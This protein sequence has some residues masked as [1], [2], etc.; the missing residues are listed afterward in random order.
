MMSRRYLCNSSI[1]IFAALSVALCLGLAESTVLY[2]NPATAGFISSA[3]FPQPYANN[4]RVTWSLIASVGYSIIANITA[5]DLLPKDTSSQNCTDYVSFEFSTII[6]GMATRYCGQTFPNIV[7]NQSR[8]LHVTFYSSPTS[9]NMSYNG[10]QLGYSLYLDNN[11]VQLN[12]SQVSQHG[13]TSTNDVK[14]KVIEISKR[15]TNS[16]AC[17]Y[18][19]VPVLNGTIFTWIKDGQILGYAMSESD[20]PYLQS[21][22][23][24]I[25]INSDKT[26][27]TLTLF[28]DA[29]FDSYGQYECKL[30]TLG[31]SITLTGS[32]KR[33]AVYSISIIGPGAVIEG[34][35]L[36]LD[37]FAAYTYGKANKTES[38]SWSHDGQELLPEQRN[39]TVS[40]SNGIRSRLVITNFSPISNQ[41]Y[42]TVFRCSYNGDDGIHDKAHTV[43]VFSSDNHPSTCHSELFDGYT[44]P[45]TVAGFIAYLP[46]PQSATGKVSRACRYR[47]MENR[48]IWE[49]VS[50]VQCVSKNFNDLSKEASN[51]NATNNNATSVLITLQ[52][53]T[54]VAN[55]ESLLG[56]DILAANKVMEKVASIS[57]EL[58]IQTVDLYEFIKTG[59]NLMEIKNRNQWLAIQQTESG[60]TKLNQILDNYCSRVGLDNDSVIVTTGNIVVEINQIFQDTQQAYQFPSTINSIYP[61]GTALPINKTADWLQDNLIIL[62]PS[63]FL[64]YKSSTKVKAVSI[65]YKTLNDIIP[66]DVSQSISYLNPQSSFGSWIPQT[67]IISTSLYPPL[68]QNLNEPLKYILRKTAADNLKYDRRMYSASNNFTCAFWDFSIETHLGGA[69]SSQGCYSTYSNETFVVCECDHLTNFAVLM[70]LSENK[71]SASVSRSLEIITYIGCGLSVIGLALNIA[72]YAI[73]WKYLKNSTNKIHLNLFSWLLVSNLIMILIDLAKSV[74]V[75]CTTLAS[76]L[77]FSLLTSFMWMLME[78][79][80]IYLFLVKVFD[81]RENF[82]YYYSASLGIPALIS[83]TT[84]AIVCGIKGI[85]FYLSS[86]GC[87]ISG[88]NWIILAFVVPLALV[89]TINLIFCVVAIHTML[90]TKRVSQQASDLLK[91]K[92]TL[93]GLSV[94]A[95]ILGLTWS[96]GC[97]LM[98]TDSLFVQY[99]FAILNSS[100]G[101][102]IFG[103]YCLYNRKVR[104]AYRKYKNRLKRPKI[105]RET[106]S[107]NVETAKVTINISTS[108]ARP[109]MYSDSAVIEAPA[110]IEDKHDQSS[111]LPMKT[112]SIPD[113]PLNKGQ[114]IYD[115]INED[116]TVDGQSNPRVIDDKE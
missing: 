69:W 43:V 80:H 1:I 44:W 54:D 97:I 107:H 65:I 102:Y 112:L 108:D 83:G 101:L 12:L 9:P 70:R 10:F 84:A 67:K 68:K 72:A 62:P 15:S 113:C 6:S 50:T 53:I 90:N 45:E 2:R 79:I 28:H 110:T 11:S 26:S 48:A 40:Q 74:T 92:V 111:S 7:Y 98:W 3:N 8:Y 47:E 60:T 77:H 49:A 57:N 94:L 116:L 71:L 82:L 81:V 42:Q 41:P 31:Q 5:F 105:S 93:R 27:T 20:P 88:R 39:I 100:Q 13:S 85:K 38:F 56:G 21:G 87:W 35:S 99:G 104:E 63:A 91:A 17:G 59:S 23:F 103:M 61:N 96:F 58:S 78:G 76:L 34:S 36:Q 73:L 55:N 46:C 86:Q 95:P 106:V 30:S 109:F 25:A 22:S 16:L 115:N 114:L 19:G 33:K 37:C 66:N 4:Q 29:A 51:L 24:S 75:L 32:L 52:T 89:F 18:T 14:N 64:G